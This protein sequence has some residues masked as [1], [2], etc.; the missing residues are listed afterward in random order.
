MEGTIEDQKQEAP[1][2]PVKSHFNRYS[3]YYILIGSVVG[4]LLT[5]EA[6]FSNSFQRFDLVIVQKIQQCIPHS[7][8]ENRAF[9]FFS[10]F[11][12]YYTETYFFNGLFCF[13]YCSFNPFI[14]FKIALLY[15]LAACFHTVLIVVLYCEPR[16]YWIDS[17]IKTSQCQPF[18]TGPTY[19]QFMGTLLMLYFI[20][21]FNHYQVFTRRVWCILFTT[22][23]VIFNLAALALAIINGQNFVYQT[24]FGIALAF[25]VIIVASALDDSV[26]LLALKVGFF[27]KSSKKY[28]FLI[29]VVLLFIFS[30]CL[31]YMMV[32]ESEP[33][34]L[35]EWMKHYGVAATVSVGSVQRQTRCLGCRIRQHQASPWL[36][37]RNPWH[38]LRC[39]LLQQIS[40]LILVEDKCD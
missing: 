25:V 17:S 22:L 23:M 39:L 30:L 32:A 7:L 38:G 16:P 37:H 35:P 2:M 33:L 4:I 6:M 18:L 19:N 9:R 28:T 40:R 10:T 11:V 5:F 36:S 24:V 14:S 29:L 34:I 27:S 20:S 13:L 1:N 8:Y 26:S 31:V 3:S 15:N 12:F 21:T